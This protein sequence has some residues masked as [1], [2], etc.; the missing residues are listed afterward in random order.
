MDTFAGGFLGPGFRVVKDGGGGVV[1]ALELAAP[2]AAEVEVCLA[3]V[4]D[5]GGRVDAVASRDGG[6][7]WLEGSVWGRAY[8]DSD[9]EDSFL[10]PGWEVEVVFAVFGGGVRGP[11][12]F[13][14]PG[15]VF[16][17]EDDAVVCHGPADGG[18]GEDMV[19]VHVILVA[20]VVEF[21][22]CFAVVGGID[23]ELAL[24]D[25]G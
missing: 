15:D 16:G 18:E 20:I 1:P 3:V 8:G 22:V 4:V 13:G 5:E 25:V 11:E 17:G 23:V 19:V 12:L 21:D 10:V 2:Q 6:W 7:F 9:S 24:E 14:D